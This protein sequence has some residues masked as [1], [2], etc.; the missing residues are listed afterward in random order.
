M[1]ESNTNK[2]LIEMVQTALHSGQEITIAANGWSMYPCLLPAD[3]VK[4]HPTPFA[5]N[6]G[7]RGVRFRWG[8][9]QAET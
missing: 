2:H 9:G 3:V 5:D 4:I 7:G 8:L 1:K 6:R